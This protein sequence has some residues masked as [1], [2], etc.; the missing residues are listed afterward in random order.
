MTLRKLA[1]I[2][3]KIEGGKSQAKIGD[4]RELLK[5]I[6]ALEAT[7]LVALE[8]EKFAPIG[9]LDLLSIEAQKKADKVLNRKTK[10]KVK[11]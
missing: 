4:I 1:S 5:I 7:H 2:L 3:A 11:K 10:K 6:I 8:Q 9:P